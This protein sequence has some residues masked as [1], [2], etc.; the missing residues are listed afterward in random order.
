ME[1]SLVIQHASENEVMHIFQMLSPVN[2]T[3]AAPMPGPGPEAL[4]EPGKERKAGTGRGNKYGIPQDLRIQDKKLYDRLYTRCRVEGILY[5]AALK[6]DKGPRPVPAPVQDP[7]AAAVEAPP[8]PVAA[9]LKQKYFVP[10]QA[11]PA[12]GPDVTY[13]KAGERSLREFPPGARVRQVAGRIIF[14]G[15]GSVKN[16]N[17]HTGGVLVEW[18]DG[19]EWISPR[20]LEAI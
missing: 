7:P 1:I 8:A 17:P 13:S 2:G 14:S 4:P 11:P 12:A 3:A 19:T 5:E 6:Q 20:Y 15:N 9:T 18:K 10:D 16:I